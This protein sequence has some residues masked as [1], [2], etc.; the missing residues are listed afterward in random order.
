MVKVILQQATSPL[1]MDGSTVFAKWRKCPLHLI[2][3]PTRV[4]IPNRISIGSAIFAQITSE[5]HYT[6]KRTT[7]FP[8]KIAHSHGRSE[9]PYNTWFLGPTWVLNP[10][11]I[12]IGSAVFAQLTAESPYILQ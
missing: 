11:G 12:S 4:Q 8:L 10:N 7:P 1:H 2:F 9:P 6:L 5:S 3:G